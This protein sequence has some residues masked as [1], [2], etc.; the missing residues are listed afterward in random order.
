MADL[1]VGKMNRR[2]AKSSMLIL[3]ELME[4]EY[5]RQITSANGIPQVLAFNVA[6][7]TLRAPA[8]PQRAS[9]KAKV[10]KLRIL[11]I[12][13]KCDLPRHPVHRA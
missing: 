8:F 10:A 1:H 12:S 13:L 7:A 9:G 4:H 11:I 5:A 2:K 3:N 6:F